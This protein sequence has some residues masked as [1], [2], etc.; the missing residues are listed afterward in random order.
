VILN[1]EKEFTD[2]MFKMHKEDMKELVKDLERRIKLDKM[3]Q[4]LEDKRT[5]EKYK[6]EQTI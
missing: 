3:L 6:V 5:E 1:N 4:D 2:H